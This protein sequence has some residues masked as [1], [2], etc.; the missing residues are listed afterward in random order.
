M[1]TAFTHKRWKK[2]LWYK[3]IHFLYVCF[4]SKFYSVYHFPFKIFTFRLCLFPFFLSSLSL[5]L[6]LKGKIKWLK[7]SNAQI[8]WAHHCHSSLSLRSVTILFLLSN[9]W[10]RKISSETMA[11]KSSDSPWEA[12]PSRFKFEKAYMTWEKQNHVAGN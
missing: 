9:T 6:R 1:Q 4:L 3:N 11:H 7:Y 5:Y 2:A 12:K 10:E 8:S